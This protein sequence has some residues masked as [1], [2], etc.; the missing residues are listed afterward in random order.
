VVDIHSRLTTADADPAGLTCVVT[1]A[2]APAKAILRTQTVWI[3]G[4]LQ[5][6]RLPQLPVATDSINK[7]WGC[8]QIIIPLERGI[9]ITADNL[10]G[11][12]KIPTAEIA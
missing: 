1:A 5:A 2:G 9:I 7:W 3:N 8:R 4:R 11:A 6:Q 12:G 10:P